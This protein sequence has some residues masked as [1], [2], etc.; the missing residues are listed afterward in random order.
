MA[1]PVPTTMTVTDVRPK[2]EV[3]MVKSRALQLTTE[4]A[5]AAPYVVAGMCSL[6]SDSFML[7][8]CMYAYYVLYRDLSGQWYDVPCLV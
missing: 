1:M 6:S 2:A 3:P 7:N 8:V 4:E 5:R